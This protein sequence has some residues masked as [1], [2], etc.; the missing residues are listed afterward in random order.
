MSKTVSTCICETN[1]IPN[2][3]QENVFFH[4]LYRHQQD[5]TSEFVRTANSTSPIQIC[6]LFST[7]G[8]D[9]LGA[10]LNLELN[11]ELSSIVAE[12]SKNSVLDFD[13]F[14][15]RVIN[16]LNIKVCEF[17]VNKGGTPLRTSM[18]LVVIE[19]DILRVINIGNTRAVLVRDGKIFSLT[20]EQ[21][22]AH[23]YVKMGVISAEQE[24]THPENATLTQYLGKMPQD[25]EIQADTK[26]HLKLKDNDELCLMGIGISKKLPASI[27]NRVLVNPNSST[28]VKCKELISA[29]F[30]NEVKSGMTAIVIK[31]ESV[32]L[33]PGDAVISG[34]PSHE[35]AQQP[36]KAAKEEATYIDFTKENDRDNTKAFREDL[37]NRADDEGGDTTMFNS[38]KINADEVRSGRKEKKEK[39]ENKV[40][41]VIIPI[42]I[43]LLFVGIGYLVM[44]IIFNA[45]H[46]VNVFDKK[47]QE[48]HEVETV[49]MYA[50]NDNTPVYAE[51]NVESAIIG[52]L[53]KGDVV[54]KSESGESFSKVKTADGIEGYVLNVQLS[55]EDPTIVEERPEI[56]SDP[57]PTPTEETT[58]EAETTPEETQQTTE[59]TTQATT[60]TTTTEATTTTSET[61]ATPTPTP[62]P[63]TSESN[64]TAEATPSPTPVETPT[65]T[66]TETPTNTPTADPTPSADTPT[67]SADTPTDTPAPVEQQ[68]NEEN[69]QE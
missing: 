60:A 49:I 12:V 51:E 39:K 7:Q 40:L 11:K 45:A 48:T 57:T 28:E 47:T 31:I 52:V 38:G 36:K 4:S 53:N 68:N 33:L 55:D 37:V 27:R 3:P 69:T 19:G 23:R 32:F 34:D 25:G 20:E 66:P 1:L 50:I 9:N 59:A 6:A 26:V 16:S 15:K 17:V 10:F 42:L 35:V 67:P 41:N 30:N 46:L 18:T 64:V 65:N 13:S 21:T 24:A 5:F 22:V 8:P 14:S 62:I 29:S 44:F 63:E 2:Q 58:T 43:L 56:E 61:V 54:S